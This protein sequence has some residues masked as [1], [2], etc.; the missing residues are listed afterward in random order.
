MKVKKPDSTLKIKLC[1]DVKDINN[2]IIKDTYLILGLE[3]FFY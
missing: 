1:N 3:M 2:K